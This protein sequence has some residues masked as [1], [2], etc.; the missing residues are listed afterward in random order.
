MKTLLSMGRKTL[1][2]AALLLATYADAARQDFYLKDAPY[3][4]VWT[5]GYKTLQQKWVT[6][7]GQTV[8]YVKA[9][10]VP[11]LFN[12]FNNLGWSDAEV[13]AMDLLPAYWNDAV[14]S[15]QGGGQ[16]ITNRITSNN[17]I[18]APFGSYYVNFPCIVDGGEYY[19][20]GTGY[21][22]IPSGQVS[23][24]TTL[25]YDRAG[26]IGGLGGTHLDGQYTASGGVLTD[27]I[28]DERNLIQTTT[29]QM[30]SGS[31][32]YT[33][34][35]HV[36]GFRL[37]GDNADWY[38]GAQ[39]I[40]NGM[41][42]WDMGETWTV[43][44]IFAESFNGYGIKCVRGTPAT[45]GELSLFV[46]ALGGINFCG[47]SLGTATINVLSG[48]DNP[49]LIVQTAGYGRLAGGTITVKLCKSESGKR[50]PNKGQ[51]I[52]WQQDPCVGLVTF[53]GAQADMN[54][55]FLDAQFVVKPNLTAAT[56]MLHVK[57]AGWNL[58]TTIHDVSNQKRWAALPYRQECLTYV[59]RDNNGGTVF[60]C[61]L[62]VML[63]S[64]PVNAPDRLGMVVNNGVF[65][66]AAGTPPYSITGGGAP[67]PPPPSCTWVTGVWGSWGACLG[68]FET[69]TR[70]V[71]S[72]VVGCTPLT[73]QPATDTTRV[74]S[75]TCTWAVGAWSAYGPCVS[76]SQ[77]RTRTVTTSLPGCTP[78]PPM[79]ATSETQ[80][81]GTPPSTAV[82]TRAP[83]N[84]TSVSASIDIPNTTFTRIELT[85]VTFTDPSFNYQRLIVEVS[86]TPTGLR[87][88]PGGRFRSPT[89]EYAQQNIANL[90]VG[91]FYPLVT[92]VFNTPITADRLFAIQ[93]TGSGIRM[94][95]SNL[96]LYNP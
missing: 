28:F 16:P 1:F 91:V 11:N 67:P 50:V 78:P 57:F 44:R 33:E 51:I 62:G 92:L 22:G 34:S 80:G 27:I 40:S 61:A 45:F 95:C 3:S 39:P 74:C 81:C 47:S 52:L 90:Q 26:W 58:R 23:T 70:S 94:T 68:G 55:Q 31:N 56:F 38:I 6:E 93:G 21:A 69:A 87:I 42:M 43:G 82:Y 13:M 30:L 71:T 53:E 54:Y 48:D 15:G 72:S 19:G 60:D 36:D 37:V 79:P 12:R 29:W 84:N 24:N 65:N 2:L 41:G 85:N 32:S 17:G 14:L 96:S 77:S 66:Y 49:A 64:S 8:A 18:Y 35:G 25:I 9:N 20:A 88:V 89:G 83:S 86:N 75:A 59:N 4:L 73:V 46:N 5:D 76:G 63:N 10:I 7:G